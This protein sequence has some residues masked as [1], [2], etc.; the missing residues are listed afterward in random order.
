MIFCLKISLTTFQGKFLVENVTSGVII[1]N[2]TLVL[3]KVRKEQAGL[4]T[5]IASNREGDGES[6]ALFL[7]VKC[8]LRLCR[9]EGKS[10]KCPVMP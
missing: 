5:C 10:S 1:V 2:Q 3:Q 4:Y 8:K 7:D 6:N 9:E